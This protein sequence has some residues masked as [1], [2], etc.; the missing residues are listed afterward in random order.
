MKWP[1]G[2]A[3]MEWQAESGKENA[4]RCVHSWGSCNESPQTGRLKND[5]NLFSRSSG[6]SKSKI[7]V[8]AG[9]VL[10]ETLIESVPGLSPNFSHNPW[11]L[12]PSLQSLRL[13]LPGI[14]LHACLCVSQ[15]LHM[16]FSSGHQSLDLGTTL[17]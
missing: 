15:S 5:R 6:G 7:K 9:L 12:D 10:L 13:S 2:Q 8:A 17:I 3:P 14:L 16:T 4:E 11:L 1:G